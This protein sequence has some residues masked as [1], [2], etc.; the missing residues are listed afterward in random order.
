MLS[1]SRVPTPQME[2]SSSQVLQLLL[3]AVCAGR[4]TTAAQKSAPKPD[5]CL[6]RGFTVD[7]YETHH[8]ALLVLLR[9]TMHTPSAEAA[10]EAPMPSFRSWLVLWIATRDSCVYSTTG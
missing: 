7:D 6:S 8:I 2:P 5:V 3:R 1:A 10:T 9:C 4:T